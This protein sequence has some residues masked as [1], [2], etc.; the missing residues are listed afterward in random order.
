MWLSFAIYK[1][2]YTLPISQI[3]SGYRYP[4]FPENV[5]LIKKAISQQFLNPDTYGNTG[6]FNGL[7]TRAAL[8]S[9]FS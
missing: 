1:I 4:I 3:S 6:I 9:S 2:P 5:D 7:L 8:V